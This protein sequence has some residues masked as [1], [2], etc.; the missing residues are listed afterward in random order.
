MFEQFLVLNGAGV[1]SAPRKVQ[2]RPQV[3]V[4]CLGTAVVLCMMLDSLS[5]NKSV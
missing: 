1:E 2:N 5:G 3:A 4:L